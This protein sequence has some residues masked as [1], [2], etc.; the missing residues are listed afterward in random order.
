MQHARGLLVI[1]VVCFLA[2]TPL[3]AE[4]EKGR[5]SFSLGLGVL[6][7]TDDIRSNA[8][9]LQVI[10]RGVPDDI[11][12]DK[13]PIETV[14]Q[15][16]DDLLGR[17]TALEES[18]IYNFGVAYGLTSWLSLQLDVGHYEGDV[19]N[20]DTFR[21]GRRFVDINNDNFL[22]EADGELL[23]TPLKD[24]SVPITV[25]SLEQIPVMLSAV[26]RFRKDSPFNPILGVGVGWM[27]TD[28]KQSGAFKDLNDQILRGFR[29]TVDWNGK[30]NNVQQ[31]VPADDLGAIP[32]VNST[33]EIPVNSAGGRMEV[34]CA[35]ELVDGVLQQWEENILPG[36]IIL[37]RDILGLPPDE[38]DRRIEEAR[39]TELASLL[40]SANAAFVPTR[41][42]ITTEIDDSFAYQIMGG[43]EYHFNA[44]W[45]AYI[46]GRYLF[47]RSTLKVR[48]SDNGNL[49]TPTRTN[50][51]SKAIV[52]DLDEAR[53]IY[54]S[55]S[56]IPGSGTG[57]G[58]QPKLV[59]DE[60]LVQ[61]GEINLSAFSLSAGIRFTF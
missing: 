23:K 12:D 36:Q 51:P 56:N 19:S 7:T 2:A 9:V 16:S 28:F 35:P 33:C 49:L 17:E 29:N 21:I 13:I 4:D 38:V 25:G 40:K 34:A 50:D 30:A 1:L 44:R 6:S 61:A 22:V 57:G 15:R 41:P 53:F 47:T 5:W 14:D 8:A 18:Q 54:L 32:I 24:A 46:I 37:W 3:I 31:I 45:S 10:E 39:Q 60:V 52:F 42:F 55:E 20:L 58:Q 43:A 27:F 59:N 26:F 48:I 11:S